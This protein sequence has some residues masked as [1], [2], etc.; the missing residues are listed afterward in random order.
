MSEYPV[1]VKVWLDAPTYRQ[2]YAHA[3][4]RGLDEVGPLLAKLAAASLKPKRPRVAKYRIIPVEV[5][6]RAVELR[7]DGLSWREIG[8]RLD[9]THSGI[10]R[11]VERAS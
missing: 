10:R 1:L 3:Q 7:R 9:V 11:A 8:A 4:Q 2:L 5:I 6:D